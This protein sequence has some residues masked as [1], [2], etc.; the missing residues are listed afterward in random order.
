MGW[1]NLP[2]KDMKSQRH[3]ELV[4]VKPMNLRAFMDEGFLQEA[5]RQFFHP[6]GL[7]LAVVFKNGEPT[8]A[9][10]VQDNREDMEGI[11]FSDIDAEKA[12]RILKEQT[13]RGVARRKAL[14]YFIQPI[15]DIGGHA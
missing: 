3:T 8:C 13:R 4:E 12:H 15:I 1:S 14:G 10:A 6:L 9:C 2:R 5:N 7:A 11:I